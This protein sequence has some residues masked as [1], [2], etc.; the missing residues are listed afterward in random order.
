MTNSLKKTVARKQLQ[1][2]HESIDLINEDIDK[3][4]LKQVVDV[5]KKLQSIDFSAIPSLDAARDAVVVDITNLVS[6]NNKPGFIDRIKGLFGN[7]SG[8]PVYTALAFGS[9]VKSFFSLFS[10]YVNAIATKNGQTVQDGER[11][12]DVLGGDEMVDAVR[13]LVEKGFQPQGRI[14]ASLG[15]GWQ[16]KYLKGG[17]DELVDDVMQMP[18]DALTKVVTNVRSATRDVGKVA[19]DVNK[20]AGNADTVP[21]AATTTGGKKTAADV[22]NQIKGDFP[23]TSEDERKTI[24]TVLNV[25]INSDLIK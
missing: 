13:K 2:L 9:A 5:V 1:T 11:V 7:D 19:T 21:A 18:I 24:K 25:L 3:A 23:G 6:G 22:W 20:Q 14:F 15:K 12:I 4:L 16:E 8:N 10:E 17:T